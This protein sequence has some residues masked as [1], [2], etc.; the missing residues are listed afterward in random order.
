M[1]RILLVEDDEFMQ[2]M[3]SLR[4]R[5]LGHEV[6]SAVN[7]KEAL[8]MAMMGSYDLILMDMQ[9]PVMDGYQA[10]KSLRERG[11]KGQI[12]AVTASAMREDSEKAIRSGC[13]SVI[14]KPVG[15]DF[16][17]QVKALM[18]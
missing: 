3:I 7:G 6:D 15:V 10:S 16:E 2:R 13:D 12:V 1:I 5:R 14:T 17:D 18:P 8:N 4:L 11:Y 9:M